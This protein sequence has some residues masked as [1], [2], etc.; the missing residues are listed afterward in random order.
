[1]WILLKLVV[2]CTELTQI[3]AFCITAIKSSGVTAVSFLNS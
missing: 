1:M 3:T 2:N